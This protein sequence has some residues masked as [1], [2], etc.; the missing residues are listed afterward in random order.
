LMDAQQGN[1]DLGYRQALL[2][3]EEL[4]ELYEKEQAQAEALRAAKEQLQ[5]IQAVLEGG[6]IRMVFQPIADLRDGRVVGV[7][8]LARFSAEPPRTPDLWFEEAEAVHLREELELAAVGEAFAEPELLPPDT[9]LSINLSP[10]TVTSPNFIEMLPQIAAERLVLEVTEHAPVRNYE[11]LRAALQDFRAAGGRLAVDDAGAG[12]ASLKHILRLAPEV[13]KLDREVAQGIDSDRGRRALA[14]ALLSF[15]SDIGAQ[16][17]AEGIETKAECEALRSM[18]V[19]FGQ[20]YY[21]AHPGPLPSNGFERLL[22]GSR[23]SG[24][25]R[26]A[27]GSSRA[28]SSA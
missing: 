3:A 6:S 9:Y 2:Y 28:Q 4:R 18:G 14:S 15:A 10:D 12:F 20:G 5:R 26:S 21:L 7:E 19:S 16:V 1:D 27:V 13:V 24:E 25:S 23:A 8:A 11:A 22:A 17:V